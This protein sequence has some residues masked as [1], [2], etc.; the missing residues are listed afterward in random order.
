M[1]NILEFD[2]NNYLKQYF[3]EALVCL[4]Y[5]INAR[6]VTPNEARMQLKLIK[7]SYNFQTYQTGLE[8]EYEQKESQEKTKTI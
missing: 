1:N 2:R 3:M 4:K 5:R 6:M 7:E 8:D